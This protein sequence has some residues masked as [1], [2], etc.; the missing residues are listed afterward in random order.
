MKRNF[1]ICQHPTVY[2][3]LIRIQTLATFFGFCVYDGGPL[4]FLIMWHDIS[5]CILNNGANMLQYANDTKLITS[6]DNHSDRKRTQQAIDNL[7]NWSLNNR[8][9]LNAAKTHHSSYLLKRVLKS[10]SYYYHGNE[11][12]I[13]TEVMEDFRCI[14]DNKLSFTPHIGIVM[15]TN[16]IHSTGFRFSKDIKI[17]HMMLKIITTYIPILDS[18]SYI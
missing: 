11:R 3:K 17:L 16:R 9:N 6:V 7:S 5:K 15:K 13:K 4:L 14:F 12:I 18:G 10:N 1:C 8:F 2:S